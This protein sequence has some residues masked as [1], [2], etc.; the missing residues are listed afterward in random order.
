MLVALTAM[1]A[2]SMPAYAAD[3]RHIG[4]NEEFPAQIAYVDA[5]SVKLSGGQA[6]FMMMTHVEGD[7]AELNVSVRQ[8]R[9]ATCQ[10]NSFKIVNERR[11]IGHI[12]QPFTPPNTAPQAAVSNSLDL[13]ALETVCGARAY[14]AE[15]IEY[16][17]FHAEKF[18]AKL[19][20]DAAAW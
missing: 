16:T 8:L 6:E 9:R 11:W 3:W 20:S 10:G 7:V 14:T 18:F 15:S 19:N 4:D 12:E 17:M 1:L 2:A 13:A 5:A